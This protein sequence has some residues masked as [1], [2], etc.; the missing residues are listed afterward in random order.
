MQGKGHAS[1][2]TGVLPC[3]RNS[4]GPSS[5]GAEA[6]QGFPGPSQPHNSDWIFLITGPL[7]FLLLKEV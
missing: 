4:W 7:D 2:K 6:G 3:V 1:M 5:V